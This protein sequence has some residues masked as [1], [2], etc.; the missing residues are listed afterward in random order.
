MRQFF[1]R[2]VLALFVSLMLL[3]PAKADFPRV[4][5][6][7]SSDHGQTYSFGSEQSRVWTELGSDHHL[8]VYTTFTNDPYAEGSA[9]RR[10]DYFTFNF[11]QVKL[12]SDGRTF[13][14]HT[15]EG[16]EIPVAL[17]KRDF[18]G[19]EEIRLLPSSSLEIRKKHG[20]LS[21]ILVIWEPSASDDSD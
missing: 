9:N 8:A 21:L 3:N 14:Y 10:Y 16:R 18:F 6:A 12:G 13:E 19:I 11:P 7:E 1:C 20:Y 5:T 15:R 4:W 2:S 17:R